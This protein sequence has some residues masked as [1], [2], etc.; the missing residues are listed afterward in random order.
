[1]K[2]QPRIVLCW[3]AWWA[4][5]FPPL[6][7]A[8]APVGADTVVVLVRHAEKAADDPKD[9]T[10]SP[11]GQARAQALLAV[12]AHAPP[13]HAYATQFRRTQLT[14]APAAH[15]SGAEVQVLTATADTAADSKVLVDDLLAH[16]RGRTVLVVGHS[17]TVPAL[18]EALSGQAIAA[19]SDGD[20][21][22]LYIVSIGADGSKRLVQSRYGAAVP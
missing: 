8:A 10:L 3:L 14:A 9:P 5:L 4:L 11:A 16:W 21:D 1:M 22:R 13:S 18:V 15:A 2:R 17:N 20:Y 6:V 19:L 7:P 12:L